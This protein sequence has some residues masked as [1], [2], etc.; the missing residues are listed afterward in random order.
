MIFMYMQC[1]ITYYNI[2]FFPVQRFHS[3]TR[4]VIETDF[5]I[6]NNCH[7]VF[8]LFVFSETHSSNF[9]KPFG[10]CINNL[11]KQFLQ[12]SKLKQRV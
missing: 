12:H 2:Q 4:L 3:E 9:L 8:F 5:N 1:L 6:K 11:D 10:Q 7:G